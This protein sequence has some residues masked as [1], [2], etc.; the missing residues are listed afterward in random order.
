M[1]TNKQICKSKDFFE[2]STVIAYVCSHVFN[3]NALA[4]IHY[5]TFQS[6]IAFAEK[7][8]WQG[9]MA[10]RVLQLSTLLEQN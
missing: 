1:E 3:T 9:A 5:I 7:I 4:E 10:S 2:P 6:W 8:S